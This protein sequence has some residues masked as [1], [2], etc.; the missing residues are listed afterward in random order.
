MKIEFTCDKCGAKHKVPSSQAGR[1]AKCPCGAILRVPGVAADFMSRLIDCPHCNTRGVLPTT[2]GNCPNCKQPLGAAAGQVAAAN[3]A[4]PGDDFVL[5]ASP[6]NMP[7]PLGV[8]PET[9]ANAGPPANL[10]PAKPLS[11]VAM[12]ELTAVKTLIERGNH[13]DALKV[14]SSAEPGLAN[15]P[16]AHYL[17]GLAYAG[18]GNF[19]HALDSL[20]CAVQGGI[21]NPEAYAAKGRAELELGQPA[22]AIESLDAALE[23]AGTDVPDYMAYLAKA[24]DGAKMPRDA[25]ATWSA[26]AQISPNHPVLI[27]RKRQK[28]EAQAKREST[29]TQQAMLQM[30]KEQRASDTACWICILLRIILE[31]M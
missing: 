31:C 29:Q 17:T 22:A 7:A 26:L 15:H 23:L 1:K 11:P 18:L 8:P 10:V 25:A 6:M 13:L 27:E 20:T 2:E 16:G 28:D 9:P 14:L 21:R 5:L 3:E 12:R 24:Y 19:P 30:Q 4:P